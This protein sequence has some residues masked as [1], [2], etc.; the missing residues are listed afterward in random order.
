MQLLVMAVSP[1]QL[2]PLAVPLSALPCMLYFSSALELFGN[3][4]G[5]KAI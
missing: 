5:G 4:C 3:S 1:L 2:L